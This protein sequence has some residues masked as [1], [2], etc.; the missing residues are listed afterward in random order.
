M[1]IKILQV[2]V[3]GIFFCQHKENVTTVIRCTKI[4]MHCISQL[5]HKTCNFYYK[6]IPLKAKF[7]V[8]HISIG[9]K[10]NKTPI[11]PNIC[12]KQE[13]EQKAST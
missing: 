8:R 9:N 10:P 7:Y 1:Y 12:T 3:N 6:R 11:E 5:L 13:G 4:P 2:F